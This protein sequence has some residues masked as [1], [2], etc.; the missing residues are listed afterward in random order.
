MLLDAGCGPGQWVQILAAGDRKVV[1]ID[2]SEQFLTV[3]RRSNPSVPFLRGSLTALPLRAGSVGG[4]L[5]WYSIIHTP[6]DALP[7]LLG[8]LRRVLR[9]DGSLLLAFVDG[10]PGLSFAHAVVTAYSWSVDALE[11]LLTNGGFEVVERHRRAD[12]GHR[13]HAA[14]MARRVA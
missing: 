7:S 9:P 11:S 8:E 14:L 3:G 5:A 12:Q 13:P 6:P 10:E 4:V 2:L 1:G